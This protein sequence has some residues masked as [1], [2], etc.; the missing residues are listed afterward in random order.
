[1]KKFLLSILAASLF[2]LPSLTQAQT[3]VAQSGVSFFVGTAAT[4]TATSGAVRLPN[5]NGAGT[6]TVIGAGITGS[7]SGCTIVLKYSSNAGGGVT[8]AISTT[9]FTPATSVQQFTITPS[10]ANGDRYT[11]VYSCSSTYPTAGTITASFS[12][13]GAAAG[14]AITV[15]NSGDA[16]ANPNVVKSSVAVNISGAAGTTELVAPSGTKS[17]YACY[18]T[19]TVVGTTPTVLFEYGTSTACTGTTALTGTMAIPTT[20]TVTLSAGGNTVITAPAS[21]GLCLVAGGTTPSIQ[22]VLSYV[23]Q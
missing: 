1:M 19:A 3:Y 17:V 18:F 20:T 12:P 9:S 16:C 21:Q 13:S 7:P 22:G 4:A 10:V 2:M 8:S 14:G 5:F 23:Q 15:T 6:L 11:A